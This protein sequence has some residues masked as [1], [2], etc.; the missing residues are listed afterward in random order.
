MKSIKNITI[1][2]IALSLSACTAGLEGLSDG[3]GDMGSGGGGGSSGG[4]L[5]FTGQEFPSD[6]ASNIVLN[7]NAIGIVV[8]DGITIDE[9]SVTSATFILTE[10]DGASSSISPATAVTGTFDHQYEFECESGPCEGLALIPTEHLSAKSEYEVRLISG[11]NGIRG[12]GGELLE[13]DITW[14]F[15][16]PDLY[17][18]ES[19]PNSKFSEVIALPNGRT[20]IT[21]KRDLAGAINP[22]IIS[23]NEDGSVHDQI[24]ETFPGGADGNI[25]AAMLHDGTLYVAGWSSNAPLN[26]DGGDIWVGAYDPYTLERIHRTTVVEADRNLRAIRIM[27]EDDQLYVVGGGENGPNYL[28]IIYTFDLEDLS[29]TST[30]SFNPA[31]AS[32]IYFADII[33]YDGSLFVTGH[34]KAI[35][36][37]DEAFILEINPDS[38]E[39]INSHTATSTP[40]P[41]GRA[42]ISMKLRDDLIYL[43]GTQMD[44]SGN[45][46]GL[47]A[48]FDP[49]AMEIINERKVFDIGSDDYFLEGV[50]DIVITD[51]GTIYVGGSMWISGTIAGGDL[52]AHGFVGEYTTDLTEIDTYSFPYKTYTFVERLGID[53]SGCV[54]LLGFAID[55]ADYTPFQYKLDLDLNPWDLIIDLL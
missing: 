5:T 2:L 48:T 40:D 29:S 50:Y 43:T 33:S 51:D 31:P 17:F 16:T 38:G 52:I 30:Y 19:Y 8:P 39:I 6:G 34:G 26:I 7:Y 44:G 28:A 4:Y 12:T 22:W 45:F 47:L 53:G 42:Y 55:G 18:I 14:S 23:M 46:Y 10:S 20:I 54:R 15:T 9:S 25:T 36:D 3:E 1:L 37:E 21:G 24:V 35:S 27:V 32:E 41:N 13:E 11:E 49:S